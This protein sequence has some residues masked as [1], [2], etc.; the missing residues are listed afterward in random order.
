[1]PKIPE[2]ENYST[3]DYRIDEMR[4]KYV[5]RKSNYLIQQ[6]SYM[7]P[8]DE[9]KIMIALIGDIRPKQNDLVVDFN[10][11][12]FVKALDLS[13]SGTNNQHIATSLQDI[14]NH[15]FWLRDPNNKHGV[16]RTLIPWFERVKQD[17]DHVGDRSHF[18]IWFTK[19]LRGY[20]L[21]VNKLYTDVTLSTVMA[22][23]NR[24][25]PRLYELFRSYK[26][27]QNRHGLKY[28]VKELKI[29]LD[30]VYRNHKTHKP[31]IKKNGKIRYKYPQ[32]SDFKKKV[33]KPAI[34]EIN[35]Y[36]PYNITSKKYRHGRRV[37]GIIV[38]MKKK[39]VE[40][41]NHATFNSINKIHHTH[42]T[43]NDALHGHFLDKLNKPRIKRHYKHHTKD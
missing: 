4:H 30:L 37:A 16:S 7:L 6:S 39:T 33:L 21:H 23:S 1:M 19:D 24:Y 28:S 29:A 20:L 3:S 9:Q 14:E 18:R 32:Y 40:Q 26:N 41:L 11:K 22:M 10:V 2:K 5:A 38:K 17:P 25:S 8:I 43:F 13:K 35:A 12:N 42:I 15:S 27:I 34:K 31:V 36:S